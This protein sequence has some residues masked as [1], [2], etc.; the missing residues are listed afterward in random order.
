M[1]MMITV[2]AA[3]IFTNTPFPEIQKK[4]KNVICKDAL[5]GDK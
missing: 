2:I 5:L 4:K 1:I 3:I